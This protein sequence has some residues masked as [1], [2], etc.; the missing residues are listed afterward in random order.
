MAPAM[1]T[2]PECGMKVAAMKMPAHM[3]AHGKVK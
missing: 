1:Q 3:K 2:C